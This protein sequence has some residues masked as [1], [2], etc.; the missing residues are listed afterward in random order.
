M[1]PLRDGCRTVVE[2]VERDPDFAKALLGAAT[3]LS[4]GGHP[5]TARL[6]LQGLHNAAVDCEQLVLL[7]HKPSMDSIALISVAVRGWLKAPF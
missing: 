5:E 7:K 3:T 4:P 2:R 6:I 1:L